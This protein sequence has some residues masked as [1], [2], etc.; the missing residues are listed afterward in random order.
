V[1]PL[2]TCLAI[3]F[4]GDAGFD[5]RERALVGTAAALLTAETLGQVQVKVLFDLDFRDARL[6]ARVQDAPLILRMELLD[7]KVGLAD[8]IHHVQVLGWTSPPRA[9]LI[10]ARLP[11]ERV[12]IHVAMHEMLHVLGVL[13]VEDPRAI[14]FF[15]GSETLW[16]AADDW[17]AIDTA[18]L[19]T[20]GSPVSITKCPDPKVLGQTGP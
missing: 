18:L 5:A 16:I 13:H 7:A 8:E 9:F 14:M 2:L 20:Q 1:F 11:D 17:K 12:F 3:L 15:K 10:P 6:L 19:T 4:H